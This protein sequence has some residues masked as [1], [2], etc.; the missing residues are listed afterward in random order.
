VAQVPESAVDQ[1][2]AEDPVVD[3]LLATGRMLIAQTARSLAQLN[4]NVTVP[5]YRTLLVL[6]TAGPQRVVDLAAELGV[7]P[8]TATRMCDR[9]VRKGMVSRHEHPGDRRAAWVLLTA[10]GR[11]LV[12]EIMRRRRGEIAALVDAVRIPDPEAFAAGLHALVVAG[13]EL[14]EAQ[15]WQRWAASASSAERLRRART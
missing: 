3:G 9:L 2:A 4:P 12:T 1:G 13:G 14:P 6:A 15:W 11:D 7:Q 8:S 10:A 5:Q